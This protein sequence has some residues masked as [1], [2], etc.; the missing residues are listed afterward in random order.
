MEGGDEA[1]RG[2]EAGP[3]EEPPIRRQESGIEWRSNTCST[4][5]TRSEVLAMVSHDLRGGLYTVLLHASSI[6]PPSCP[7]TERHVAAIRRAA[8]RM[9]ALVQDL[10]DAATLDTGRLTLRPTLE[11]PA[12]MA[13]E[14]IEALGPL[15]AERNVQLEAAVPDAVPMVRC[16][17]NRML[18]VLSNLLSNAIQFSPCGGRVRL[19]AAPLG[20]EVRISVADQG[21]GLREADIPHL[22]EPYW[23]GDVATPGNGLGLYIAKRVVDAHGGRIWAESQAGLGSTFVVTLPAADDET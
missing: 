7:E 8:L 1:A 9:N 22:F 19:L 5:G 14:A 23:R 16:D 20:P 11:S 13:G 12:S 6:D 10:L 2:R 15:A 21:P 4:S 3:E 17:R 18:Q